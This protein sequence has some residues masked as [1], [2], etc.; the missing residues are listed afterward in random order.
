MRIDVLSI[1][2]CPNSPA[3]IDQVRD[4]LD[5][6][7]YPDVPVIERRITT[8]EEAAATAFAGSPTILINGVDIVPGTVPTGSLACRV[9]RTDTGMAGRPTT[10]QIAEA[11]RTH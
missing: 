11:I 8:P 4:A 6:L 2:D 7:G 1:D 5:S 9:Y 3:A 10:A